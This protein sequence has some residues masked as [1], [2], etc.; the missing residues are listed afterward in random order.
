MKEEKCRCYLILTLAK[1][2]LVIL[3]FIVVLIVVMI[4]VIANDDNG[5]YNNDNRIY[6]NDNKKIVFKKTKHHDP[7]KQNTFITDT[8]KPSRNVYI[9]SVPKE[10]IFSHLKCPVS[11][12]RL[13]I[14]N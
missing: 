4:I 10:D 12:K 9:C 11:R 2:I 3:V 14:G 1:R 7:Q 13:R 5:Y 6:S 8:E